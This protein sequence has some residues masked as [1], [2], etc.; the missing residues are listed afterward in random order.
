VTTPARPLHLEGPGH[1]VVDGT[2][3]VRTQGGTR[4][5]HHL[6]FG[7][8]PFVADLEPTQQ[9]L[10]LRATLQGRLRGA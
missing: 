4:T 2:F 3:Q 8:G 7:T 9:G 10:R 6:D 5:L 1:I